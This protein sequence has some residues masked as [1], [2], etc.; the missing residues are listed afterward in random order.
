MQTFIAIPHETCNFTM[1][2]CGSKQNCFNISS[3]EDAWGGCYS[4]KPVYWT[5]TIS[6][7]T[8][9]LEKSYAILINVDESF[10]IYRDMFLTNKQYNSYSSEYKCS[11]CE[12]HG[13]IVS[14]DYYFYV[15]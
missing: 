3:C 9:R 4:T 6:D 2:T 1:S 5:N 14:N 7:R 15:V 12:W 13:S 11:D 8:S 10:Y